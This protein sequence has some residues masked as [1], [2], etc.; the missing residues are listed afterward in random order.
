MSLH[1]AVTREL[2]NV[3]NKNGLA[4]LP[5]LV[6]IAHTH[7]DPLHLFRLSKRRY[8]GNDFMPATTHVCCLLVRWLARQML[9]YRY[10]PTHAPTHPHTHAR[11]NVTDLS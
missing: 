2:M 1:L 8:P 10:T 6:F 11:I 5:N 7:R 9:I 3:V 4:L